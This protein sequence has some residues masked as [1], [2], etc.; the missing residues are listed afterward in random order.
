MSRVKDEEEIADDIAYLAHLDTLDY[1]RNTA[2]V[3][4]THE[5]LDTLLRVSD[6]TGEEYE[7][8]LG[9]LLADE[10]A[11]TGPS[12]RVATPERPRAAGDGAY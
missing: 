5:A 8:I 7:A 1:L 2:P 10:D 11:R 4:I 12:L 6:R 3:R 9:R